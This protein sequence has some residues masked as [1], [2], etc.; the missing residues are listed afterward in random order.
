M[1][2]TAKPNSYVQGPVRARE[3]SN[4]SISFVVGDSKPSSET[5]YVGGN[6]GRG[7]I[8]P[9]GSSSNI[10][11][12][13]AIEDSGLISRIG[14]QPKRYGSI[15]NQHSPTQSDLLHGLTGQVTRSALSPGGIISSDSVVS[16]ARNLGGFGGTEFTITIQ[17]SSSVSTYIA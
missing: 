8:Y 16:Q 3:F 9:D 5:V 2:S 13:R 15:V 12:T 10:G 11:I 4:Q 14:F 1:W 7:Q 6:R 17:T